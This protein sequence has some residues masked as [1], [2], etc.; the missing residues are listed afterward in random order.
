MEAIV[1]TGKQIPKARLMTL[2]AGLKLE[3]SGMKVSRG[4][5]CYSIIKK[6]FGW[7]GGREKIMARLTEEIESMPNS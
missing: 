1:L 3:M 6:E 4:R 7:K 5:T 2:R